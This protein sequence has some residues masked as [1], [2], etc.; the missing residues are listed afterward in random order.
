MDPLLYTLIID[1]E[2]AMQFLHKL[3]IEE[4]HLEGIA[5]EILNPAFGLRFID[6]HNDLDKRFL[7]LLDLN[8]PGM[9]G[10]TFLDIVSKTTRQAE[11]AVVVATS[12][13]NPIDKTKVLS[14]PIVVEYIEKPLAG[15]HLDRLANHPRIGHWIKKCLPSI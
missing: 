13:V 3:V 14:Y 12:S 2:P 6:M 8:M 11:V 7:V 5:L 4:W 9:D 1:D 10:W 15:L